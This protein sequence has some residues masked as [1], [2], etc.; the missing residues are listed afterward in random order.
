MIEGLTASLTVAVLDSTFL[1]FLSVTTQRTCI[2]FQLSVAVAVAVRAVN[3]F[4]TVQLE[5]PDFLVYHL[6][7]SPVPTTFMTNVSLSPE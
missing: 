5:A 2:P 3:S 7:F 4:H 1:P 6:Y